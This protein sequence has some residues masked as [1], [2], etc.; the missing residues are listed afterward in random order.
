MSQDTSDLLDEDS[1]SHKP[2]HLAII[3]DGNNRWAKR[4]G[5]RQISGHQEGAQKLRKLIEY[6]D[7]FPQIQNLTVFAFS[8]ENW[9]RSAEEVNSLMSLF[10]SFLKK[11]KNILLERNVRLRII[12][13]RDKFSN[14]LNKLI[15]E[16]EIETQNLSRHLVL[17]VDYGGRWDI[18][19]A[20]KILAE[21]VAKG[22]LVAADIDETTI[23][24]YMA[25][26]DLPAPDLL[27]RTGGEQRISNFLLWQLAYTEI[28]ITETYWPDF[29]EELLREALTAYWYRNRRFGGKGPGAQDK[30]NDS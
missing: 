21:K 3:M 23:G 17:A 27:I 1:N 9:R 13:K 10:Y 20:A 5:L 7:K 30:T 19:N 16:V 18:T 15:S 24:K 12:G 26:S 2:V 25:L 8:S 22:E 6:I 14:R 28:F 4:R 11:Y 29:S